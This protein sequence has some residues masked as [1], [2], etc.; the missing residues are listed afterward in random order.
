MELQTAV[1]LLAFMIPAYIANAVPVVL[2]GGTKLD[3][4]LGFPDGRRIFGDG[5][6]VRGFLAGVFGG[7]AAGGILSMLY[8]VPFFPSAGVQFTGFALMSFGTMVGDALGSFLKRRFGIEPGKP[9]ILDQLMFLVVALMLVQP[10]VS[11]AVYGW[12]ALLFLFI[13]TYVLHVGSNFV[14]NRLGWKKVPW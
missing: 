6:T 2:G 13:T 3:F 4:G 7:I 8:V 5:K 10:Y 1:Y 9:F 14:A 12:D 11:P